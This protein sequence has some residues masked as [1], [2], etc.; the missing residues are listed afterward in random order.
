[1]TIA[2]EEATLEFLPTTTMTPVFLTD[3][4]TTTRRAATKAATRMTIAQEEA[5]L[6]VLPT[7]T[8]TPVILTDRQ[9]TN[10]T[11]HLVTT[12]VV[13]SVTLSTMERRLP[14]LTPALQILLYKA[15]AS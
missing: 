5:T 8:M 2:Q 14:V 10:R 15:W 12:Q 7:T 1:M 3:R 9:T 4:Q 6:E 11:V 13:W